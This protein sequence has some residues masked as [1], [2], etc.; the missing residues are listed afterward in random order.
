MVGLLKNLR[1]RMR[2]W[3]GFDNVFSLIRHLSLVHG[4]R[5][6][7]GRQDRWQEDLFVL[8]SL[9]DLIP[10]DHILRRVDHVLDLSWLREEVS[11]CYC[12]DNG[13][14][15]VDPEAAVR[16]MLAGLFQG[17]VHDRELMRETQVN[18][19]IRWFAGYRLQEKLPDHSSLTRIRQRWG[20]DRFKW[21]FQR[22]VEACV[23]AGLVVGELVHIDATLIR[24]D[25]SWDSLINQQIDHVWCENQSE[26]A[27]QGSA[28][29][30]KPTRKRQ[31][32]TDPDCSLA[33]SNR[34]KKAEPSYKQHTTVDDRKGVVLDV[35]VTTGAV[36]ESTVIQ[37]QMKQTQTTTGIKIQCLTADAGYAYG[38][39]YQAMEVAAID[40]IIP[41]KQEHYS[42]KRLPA[43][44]FKYDGKHHIGRCP[45]GKI[46]RRSTRSDDRWHYRSKTADCRECPLRDRC[47]SPKSQR[48]TIVISDEHE[49]LIRARRDRL[50][51]DDD[52]YRAYQRHCWR[53]EGIHAEAKNRHGL[54]RAARRGIGN[55][56]IQSYLTAAVINLKRLAA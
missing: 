27:S 3:H 2:F 43:R 21:I 11:D 49:A 56:R 54:H 36:N 19:A 31:S 33:T 46:L 35:A 45:Q 38:K 14:P 55:I 26:P 15:G 16:L 28:K 32:V 37:E 34:A 39:V 51:W 10:E 4:G 41:P 7:I 23:K 9:R 47:L 18:L 12:K 5:G 48:R 50:R 17:I 30:P 42:G 40:A 20:V 53:A 52:D 44:K 22:T 24:A 29:T 13:R 6:M 8:G 1:S 25:V